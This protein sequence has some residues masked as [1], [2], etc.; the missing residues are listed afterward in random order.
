LRDAGWPEDDIQEAFRLL[1]GLFDAPDDAPS[2]KT[3]KTKPK[4]KTKRKKRF[5][6]YI[7]AATGVVF[8]SLI[9]F[10]ICYWRFEIYP[11]QMK[12]KVIKG[13]SDLKV[14]RVKSEALLNEDGRNYKIAL[15]GYFNLTDEKSIKSDINTA[16]NFPISRDVIVNADL[17]VKATDNKVY[18]K[19][20]NISETGVIDMSS[21]KDKWI[22]SNLDETKK[23]AGEGVDKT[24]ISQN[25]FV[26][27]ADK[28]QLLEG[29]KKEK[30]EKVEGIDCYKFTFVIKKE[31]LV[32]FLVTNMLAKNK[33]VTDNDVQQYRDSFN[34]SFEEIQSI[35]GSIISD[36]KDFVPRKVQ[37]GWKKANSFAEISATFY[38]IGKEE[39]IDEP[40]DY[41]DFQETLKTIFNQSAADRQVGTTAS[42]NSAD[43]TANAKIKANAKSIKLALESCF[44]ANKKYPLLDDPCVKKEFPEGAVPKDGITLAVVNE[45]YTLTASL[46][47]EP[48]YIL[49]N[50]Q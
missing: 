44:K 27:I 23:M 21:L 28:K 2:S 26:K 29:F 3:K 43:M 32:D 42:I 35:Q 22:I 8:L 47:G 50:Q 45:V 39:K 19:L 10:S 31:K 4:R 17:A 49:T 1:G 33:D 48:A 24:H 12:K 7:L 6:E 41:I 40:K 20:N 30:D 38:D 13:I 25:E 46:K 15:E 36:K 14:S 11:A 5:K 9:I 16:I 37:L 34:K 18:V